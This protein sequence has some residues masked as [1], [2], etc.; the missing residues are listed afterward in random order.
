MKTKNDK[1]DQNELK[2]DLEEENMNLLLKKL[3]DLAKGTRKP[4]DIILENKD[5][6]QKRY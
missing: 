2:G 6:N 5:R 4:R 3:E 1:E